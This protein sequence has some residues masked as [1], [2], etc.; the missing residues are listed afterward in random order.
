MDKLVMLALQVTKV[1]TVMELMQAKLE[2]ME[3]TVM[4]AMQETLQQPQ[5]R[6]QPVIM[7][8]MVLTGM[9]VLERITEILVMLAL[10]EIKALMVVERTMVMLAVTG[11][12]VMPVLLEMLIAEMQ[13]PPPQ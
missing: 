7:D 2:V 12:T 10:Q 6:V 9:Q 11:P 13:D 5:E 3:Q 1:Q 8:L 4:P